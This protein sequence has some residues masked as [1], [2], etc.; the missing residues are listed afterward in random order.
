MT[1]WIE[2][3]I[4][5]FRIK[6]LKHVVRHTSFGAKI[7]VLNTGAVINPEAEAMLQ[8]LHSRS[9]KGVD[10]HLGILAEKGSEKFMESFY[11][12]YGHK[13]IGDC[14]TITI[15]IEGCSMLAAKAIQDWPLYSGQESSTRY[16]DFSTQPFLNP[17]EI[18]GWKYKRKD[19]ACNI[20]AEWRNFYTGALDEVKESLKKRFPRNA[21]ENESIYEKAISARTFDIMRGFLPAGAC[22]NLAWHTN[23]RQA[24]DKLMLL[25]HH[26]LHEV[27]ALANSIDSALQEAFPSSFGH[28]KYEATENY[29][30]IVMRHNYFINKKIG[31]NFGVVSDSIHRVGLERYKYILESRPPKTELPKFLSELGTIQLEF[32]LDYGSYRDIQR[33]RSI[34]QRM[35]LL[36]TYFGFHPWYLDELPPLVRE[37]AKNLIEKQEE[38]IKEISIS[39]EIIQ[40]YLAMGYRVSNKITGSLPN[41]VYLVELRATRFVHPTLRMVAEMIAEELKK[42]FGPYGLRLYLDSEPNRFDVRRG[43]HDIVLKN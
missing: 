3:K 37:K 34:I 9:S 20:L 21:C 31:T 42:R 33:H 29:N 35:P 15:F 43:E 36:T 11:V 28:K 1:D 26:K 13:S 18:F 14:G 24:A 12:G 27:R 2:R 41:L 22:T 10:D 32:L 16:L 7:L 17:I 4:K 23:L 25:R 6:N 40:Y 38:R 39:P 5:K 19:L 30:E 8:A